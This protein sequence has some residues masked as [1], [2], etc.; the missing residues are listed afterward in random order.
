MSFEK[1][2]WVSY[3]SQ[4]RVSK[5]IDYLED[6]KIYGTK[7]RE[8]GFLQFPPRAHCTRC[9]SNSFEWKQ[10][11][12]DCT[13]ITY[14]RVDASPT[15]FKEKAPYLL[16]L[17]QLSEGPKVFTWIDKKIPEDQIAIGMKLQLMASKLSNGKVSY[18]LTSPD[19][20]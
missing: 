5:F 9:L 6:G 15:G 7:C 19:G 13:L 18:L 17:A 11:S 1:F 8:C 10:L 2:G 16:G 4:T 12:G 3:A 14:T 20:T